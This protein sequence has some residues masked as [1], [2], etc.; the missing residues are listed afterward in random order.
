MRGPRV[1]RREREYIKH[2]TFRLLYDACMHASSTP[3][4]L[5]NLLFKC[6]PLV[7]IRLLSVSV[8]FNRTEP[9]L[10]SVRYDST[11]ISQVCLWTF[12]SFLDSFGMNAFPSLLELIPM[13][14]SSPSVFCTTQYLTCFSWYGSSAA[15]PDLAMPT[16]M[17]LMVCMYCAVQQPSHATCKALSFLL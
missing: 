7:S 8:S 13:A 12:V 17:L 6:F 1:G 16:D 11:R 5:L 10:E 4:I 9:H 15:Q 2:N 14:G 3:A